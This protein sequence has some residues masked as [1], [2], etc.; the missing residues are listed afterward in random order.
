MRVGRGGVSREV[1]VVIR[2]LA[3]RMPPQ[4]CSREREGERGEKSRG[5]MSEGRRGEDER[6]ERGNAR[7][8]ESASLCARARHWLNM[9]V[10]D[11]L[12]D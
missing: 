5:W 9:S 8:R 2:N 7:Q 10:R 4:C 12:I 1:E 11:W 3:R 6:R